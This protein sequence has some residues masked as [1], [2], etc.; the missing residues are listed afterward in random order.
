MKVLN[1]YCPRSGKP[2]MKDSLTEYRNQIVGFCNPGCRD[3]FA[4]H[5]ENRPEDRR[6]FD[7]LI[8]EKELDS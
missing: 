1:K 5:Q 8:K 7:T 2:V 4:S 3:D 6:Y